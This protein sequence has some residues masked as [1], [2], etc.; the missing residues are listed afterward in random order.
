MLAN[1]RSW[2]IVLLQIVLI[3][4]SLSLSWLLRFEF[5]LPY[6][7][8]LIWS[9]PVL[10]LMRIAAMARFH[11]FHG[12]WR[13]TGI[14]DAADILK[15]VGLGSLGFVIGM[16]WV[17]GITAFP[18]SIYL[19]E[20]LLTTVLLAGVRLFSRG[21]MQTLER[22]CARGKQTSV[23]VAGAGTAAATLVS[24]LQRSGCVTVG[25]VDDDRGKAGIRLHGV[26]VIGTIAELPELARAHGI[27]E[28]LIAIPS[29]TGPQMRRIIDYCHAAGVRFR[30]IPGLADLIDG[31]V[32]VQQLRDVNVEDLLGREP[33]RLDLENVRDKLQGRV[34]MVTGA[35]GSIGS[36]LCRQILRYQPAKLICVDQAETPLF[37]LQRANSKAQAKAAYCVADLTD[38]GRMRSILSAEGV[39]IVFHAAAYKHVPLME[40]NLCEA[41][42]NNVFGTLA[43]VEAA[44]R[45]VAGISC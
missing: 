22:R 43:L 13:Y 34:V 14:N 7:N 17:L 28:I 26:P 29:A 19:L 8:V 18:I 44:E 12:Y 27:D 36:E 11:L 1:R 42:R 23:I 38:S 45:V 41:L 30:T 31:T 2:A 4:C 35:A 39:D 16:R 5:R 20:A 9:C 40:E 21:L 10:V 15:A 3:A 24:E 25:L 33:V 6:L 37:Y 32:T